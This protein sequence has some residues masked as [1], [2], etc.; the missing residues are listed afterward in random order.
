MAT[1]MTF[2]LKQSGRAMSK[3][4]PTLQINTPRN[5]AGLMP[6][7]RVSQSDGQSPGTDDRHWRRDGTGLFLGAGARLQMAGPALAWSI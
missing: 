2:S 7:K 4:T 3:Q 6:T 1:Y 5:A